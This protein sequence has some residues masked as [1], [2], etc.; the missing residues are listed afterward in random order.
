MRKDAKA[1][2]SIQIEQLEGKTVVSFVLPQKTTGEME[3]LSE[4]QILARQ[5]DI[6]GSFANVIIES[7]QRRMEAC[8]HKLFKSLESASVLDNG[9]Q[10]LYKI[11]NRH[12]SF[13]LP[14]YQAMEDCVK[15]LQFSCF[16]EVLETPEW[17]DQILKALL[18]DPAEYQTHEDCGGF[19]YSQLISLLCERHIHNSHE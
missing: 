19:A 15:A 12:E 14:S 5:M 11:G 6:L 13:N 18:N 7:L 1:T 4:S 10:I 17:I 9:A 16:R 3:F 2:H 8:K